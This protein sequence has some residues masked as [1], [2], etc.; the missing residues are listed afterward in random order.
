VIGDGSFFFGL[1]ALGPLVAE[2]LAVT[3]VVVDNGGFGST[4]YFEKRYAR[5]LADTDRRT[6]H[7]IGSDFSDA[8][9]SICDLANGAGLETRDLPDAG[10]LA[11]HLDELRNKGPALVRVPV[12]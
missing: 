6:A 8:K 12:C 7:Q 10:E 5:G 3:I 4:Q 11:A 2:G 9:P 1:G